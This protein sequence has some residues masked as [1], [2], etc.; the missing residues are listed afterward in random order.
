MSFNGSFQ[1]RDGAIEFYQD[2]RSKGVRMYRVRYQC[3]PGFVVHDLPIDKGQMR[4]PQG[5]TQERLVFTD[6]LLFSENIGAS[7]G[8]FAARTVQVKITAQLASGRWVEAASGIL[9]GQIYN[10]P[11]GKCDLFLSSTLDGANIYITTPLDAFDLQG[12]LVEVSTTA[13]FAAGTVTTYDVTTNLAPLEFNDT[14]TRWTRAAAYDSFGKTGLVWSDTQSTVK[15][16]I[17]ID[18]AVEA[19]RTELND[20]KQEVIDAVDE[21]NADLLASATNATNAALAGVKSNVIAVANDLAAETTQRELAVSTLGNST[22]ASLGQITTRVTNTESKINT[23]EQTVASHDTSITQNTT[24]VNQVAS[25]ALAET[26]RVNQ[27]VASTKSGLESSITQEA[28]ARTNADSATNLLVSNLTTK[29]NDNTAAIQ[30]EAS[31][32]STELGSLA[33]QIVSVQTTANQAV[34]FRQGSQPTGTIREGA[35]WVNTSDNNRLYRY[36]A[37]N[38]VEV[39]DPRTAQNTTNISNEVTARTNADTALGGRIDTLTSTVSGNFASLTQADTTNSN[40]TSAVAS[41]AT[42]LEAK[43]NGTTSSPLLT[44]INDEISARVD[45][46]SAQASRSNTIEAR[47]NTGGDIRV[48]ITNAQN[49]AVDAQGKVNAQWSLISN[50]NGLISGIKS[51]NNGTISRLDLMASRIRLLNDSGAGALSPFTVEGGVVK[52]Q[53]VSLSG[54]DVSLN[55]NNRFIVN[56]SGDCSWYSPTGVLLMKAGTL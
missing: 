29:V 37:G 38:W 24:K 3:G 26:T 4:V 1:G 25:D 10:P 12:Y 23:V 15:K 43:M 52:M 51:E 44:K 32:R 50:A 55:V 17:V 5:G 35:L 54:A 20:F 18:G 34:S 2:E 16:D 36:T 30:S 31:T 22:A 8:V 46:D 6:T 27:L 28:T 47:L 13:N 33:S 7:G 42:T 49:V 48:S 41:R 39:T 19:I 14:N 11:P 45:G 21:E 9:E 40:A 56:A 53:K